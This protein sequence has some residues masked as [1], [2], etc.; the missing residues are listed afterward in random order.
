[1]L[2]QLAEAGMRL[3]RAVEQQAMA[4]AVPE[5]VGALG[6]MSGGDL[7]LAYSRL[8]RAVRQTLALKAKLVEDRWTLDHRQAADQAQRAATIKQAR[9]AAQKNRVK[10]IVEGAIDAEADGSDRENL[11]IDLDLRLDDEDLFA[12]YDE[13][14]F[15]EIVARICRDLGISPDRI[16]W[17]A[18]DWGIEETG[19]TPP[20]FASPGPDPEHRPD[21]V[22]RSD[23]GYWPDPARNG[24]SPEP[25]R[26]AASGTD[27]P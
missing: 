21:P 15:G 24:R 5:Q 23:P 12:D 18:E 9:K 14:P 2:D 17:E 19:T 4:Q 7:A 1:M 11:L 13:R 10:R 26:V 8:A 25:Q 20:P 3:V 22:Y 16:L 6:R 27:P